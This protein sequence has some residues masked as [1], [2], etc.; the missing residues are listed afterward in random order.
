M[1]LQQELLEGFSSTHIFTLAAKMIP[2]HPNQRRWEERTGCRQEVGAAVGRG[3]HW[4]AVRDHQPALERSEVH[5]GRPDRVLVTCWMDQSYGQGW[6]WSLWEISSA[7]EGAK[8]SSWS[9]GAGWDVWR[10][11]KM[12]EMPRLGGKAIFP[13]GRCFLRYF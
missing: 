1:F 12:F 13:T 9:S 11:H 6:G 4:G 5:R 3:H 10:C 8:G 7:S 2:P